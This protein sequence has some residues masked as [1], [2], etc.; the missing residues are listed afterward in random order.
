MQIIPEFKNM[1]LL[2]DYTGIICD[3]NAIAWEATAYMGGSP[4]EY[5]LCMITPTA[6]VWYQA[7]LEMPVQFAACGMT[8]IGIV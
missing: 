4:H 7:D 6:L 2:W 5:V 8:G 1:W 3:S